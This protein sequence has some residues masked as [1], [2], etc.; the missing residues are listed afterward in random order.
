MVK[1]LLQRLTRA[2]FCPVVIIVSL[3]LSPV[4]AVEPEKITVEITTHL[5][6]QQIFVEGDVISFLLSLDRDAYIYLFYR[7]ADGNNFQILPNRHFPHHFYRK[8]LFMQIPPPQARFLFKV[9]PPFGR[10]EL[11]VFASDNAEI[12]FS[13]QMPGNGLRLVEEPVSKLESRI[14]TQSVS[15]FGNA[16]LEIVIQAE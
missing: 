5:G 14:R 8:G 13:G 10:E 4:V 7:D 1:L 15:A 9:G 3:C 2:I 12:Q 16:S 11:F 6:D